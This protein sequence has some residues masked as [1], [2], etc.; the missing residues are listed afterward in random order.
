M[1]G[2]CDR[3]SSGLWGLRGAFLARGYPGMNNKTS[4]GATRSLPIDSLSSHG[5]NPL[6]E[7]R[8][9]LGDLA[10]RIQHFHCSGLGLI[11]GWG[12]EIRQAMQCGQKQTN[13]QR[14]TKEKD[15]FIRSSSS[16][17]KKTSG[18]GGLAS[19]HEESFY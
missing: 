11:L 3:T 14:K 1:A 8:E 12:T 18:R 19:R 7:R 15:H 17:D 6:E 2:T 5:D 9:F 4:Q 13:T 16:T 10:V